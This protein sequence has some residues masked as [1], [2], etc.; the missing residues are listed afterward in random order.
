MALSIKYESQWSLHIILIKI[1]SRV[2]NW[3]SLET[4]VHLGILSDFFNKLLHQLV[5]ILQGTLQISSSY[6]NIIPHEPKK[7]REFQL[8]SWLMVV[9]QM[10]SSYQNW[11]PLDPISYNLQHMKMIPRETLLWMTF[12]TTLILRS[13]PSFAWKVI[14]YV[15]RL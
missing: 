14:V 6:A 13:K 9:G 4:L 10:N 11:V 8:A 2:W 15:E 5:K 12:Q 1:S 7:S 3:F